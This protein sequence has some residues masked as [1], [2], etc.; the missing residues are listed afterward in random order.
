MRSDTHDTL[1]QVWAATRPEEPSA[2][3]FDALWSEVTARA[4]EPEILP[5]SRFAGRRRWAMAGA[6]LASA[7]AL[8][9]A[10]VTSLTPPKPEVQVAV[11]PAP[12]QEH[13]YTNEVGCTTRVMLGLNGLIQGVEVVPQATD[14]ETDVVTAESDVLG[15]MEAC[16]PV[17]APDVIDYSG[18]H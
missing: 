4:E 2:A 8:L 10:A 3:A 15:F 6:M 12:V 1:G 9:I 17:A 14:S 5:M 18:S 16:D 11:A 13:D 7:A